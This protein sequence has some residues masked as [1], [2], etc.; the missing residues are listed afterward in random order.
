MYKLKVIKVAFAYIFRRI[1][2]GYTDFIKFIYKH[3]ENCRYKALWQMKQKVS[4]KSEW[5]SDITISLTPKKIYKSLAEPNQRSITLSMC[6]KW[7]AVD[8]VWKKGTVKLL[9]Q[10]T[11]SY[12]LRLTDFLT[13]RFVFHSLIWFL[14]HEQ[15]QL[16]C[17]AWKNIE[18]PFILLQEVLQHNYRLAYIAVTYTGA[19][20]DSVI[21]QKGLDL[22][23]LSPYSSHSYR[24]FT[25]M[26][27][28]LK[29]A[30]VRQCASDFFPLRMM[31]K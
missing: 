11:N 27:N 17:S 31:K 28:V 22:I 30:S 16:L 1:F 10:I 4:K 3:Y 14:Y 5:S 6:F 2:W 24:S 12:N 20:P 21:L 29:S 25:H 23:T 18:L 13:E 8:L 7:W 19:I 26:L 9:P 15:I